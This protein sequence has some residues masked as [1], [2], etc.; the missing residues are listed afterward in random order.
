[1]MTTKILPFEKTDD[2]IQDSESHV[3]GL[4]AGRLVV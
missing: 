3:Y 2:R 1:M 4:A